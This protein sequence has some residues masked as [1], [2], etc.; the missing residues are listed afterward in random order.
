MRGLAAT[1]TFCSLL[2]GSPIWGADTTFPYT[3]EVSVDE[4]EV[5]C[6]PDW[7]YYPT[8]RLKRGTK[9]DVY[10]HDPGGWLAIRPPQ[11]SFSWIPARQLKRDAGSRVGKLVI[12]GA[13]AWVGTI[14]SNVPQYKWQVRLERDEMVE[15][16]GEKSLSVG[17]GFATETYCKI[18]PP[19]GEFRWIHAENAVSPHSVAGRSAAQ[20][21]DRTDLSAGSM[22]SNAARGSF[23]TIAR[24][25]S[26][27]DVANADGLNVSTTRVDNDASGKGVSGKNA[28]EL[29]ALG[30]QVEQLKLDL[31]LLATRQIEQWDIESLQTR[32]DK[33][34]KTAKG[35]A[36]A[37]QV[38]LVAYR[39]GEFDTLQK[40]HARMIENQSEN[41][42]EDPRVERHG[43]SAAPR[44]L[45][46]GEVTRTSWQEK[47][48]QALDATA[49]D[50]R[51]GGR[52]PGQS[53]TGHRATGEADTMVGT[54]IDRLV[55]NSAPRFDAEG[56]LMP[57]H[58][59]RRVAP[60]FAL[61]DDDG[62]VICY[63]QPAPGLNLRRHAK[64]RV[65]LFGE[66][67]FIAD[68]R[69]SLLTVSRVVKQKN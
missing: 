52:S 26:A 11:G 35:T 15:I 66:K 24:V 20:T 59:T 25:G 64:K 55:A 12:D 69:A 3:A 34:A 39:I 65:G 13:V 29:A 60:P 41:V 14:A 67:R 51:P 62:R 17:P 4:V 43:V 63:V 49:E 38:R 47:I 19:A 42:A 9:V 22:T 44:S 16:L 18:T 6:G 31:T 28:K 8:M 23:A 37:R 57:V 53:A 58:S 32:A 2:F 48:E 27:P 54:G 68:L 33:L 1:M 30:R 5:R 56:W 46:R 36:W 50:R 21:T 61:L 45:E 10:R 40:R 7:E